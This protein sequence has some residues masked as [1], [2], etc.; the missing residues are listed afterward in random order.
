MEILHYG[1]LSPL[2]SDHQINNDCIIKVALSTQRQTHLQES[3]GGDV[4][5]CTTL[6]NC[7]QMVFSVLKGGGWWQGGGGGVARVRWLNN[8]RIGSAGGRGVGC[9]GQNVLFKHARILTCFAKNISTPQ[10]WAQ[11]VNTR[12]RKQCTKALCF[13]L[14]CSAN[15]LIHRLG[16]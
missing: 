2:H 13:R 14:F 1:E 4:C 8:A 6:I 7:M 16:P 5:T 15:A 11:N 3:G 12:Q 10:R 9:C